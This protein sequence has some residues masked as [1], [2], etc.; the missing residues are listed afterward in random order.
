ML[1]YLCVSGDF[2]MQ[3]Y[4]DLS[5]LIYIYFLLQLNIYAVGINIYPWQ[6]SQFEKH[7]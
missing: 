7:V 4:I 1:I 5:H 2:Y 3:L 6:I